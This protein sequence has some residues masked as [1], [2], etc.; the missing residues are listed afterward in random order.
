MPV[1]VRF[2]GQRIQLDGQEFRSC[3][4]EEC[5]IVYSG[6]GGVV[7][8]SNQF[9]DC[10]WTLEGPAASTLKFL[11]MLHESGGGFRELIENTIAAMTGKKP[12]GPRLN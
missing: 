10:R 11:S 9:R 12:R 4:F 1:G 5:E 2:H 6:A 7:L 3:I 8:D